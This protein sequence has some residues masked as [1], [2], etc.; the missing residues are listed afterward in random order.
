MKKIYPVRLRQETIDDL[1]IE[2]AMLKVGPTTHAR[3]I[4]EGHFQK[5]KEVASHIRSDAPGLNKV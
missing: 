1:E 3:M 4:I 5:I 2:A